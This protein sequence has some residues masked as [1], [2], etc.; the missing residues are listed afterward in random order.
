MIRVRVMGAPSV[1]E[2]MMAAAHAML[3]ASTCDRFI[4]TSEGKWLKVRPITKVPAKFVTNRE[5]SKTCDH[6]HSGWRSSVARPVR[7][8]IF[9]SKKGEFQA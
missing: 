8:R 3:S 6:I 1:A 2:A 5:V 9:K 7:A 4:E